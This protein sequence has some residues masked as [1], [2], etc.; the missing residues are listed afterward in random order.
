M[1]NFDNNFKKQ[2]TMKRI[3]LMLSLF[4]AVAMLSSCEEYETVYTSDLDLVYTNYSPEYNFKSA[5]TYSIP[6][7][8]VLVKDE[9]FDGTKEY[10]RY[11]VDIINAIKSNMSAYGWT[12]VPETSNPDVI[13]LPSISSTVN[14]YYYYSWGYWGSYYPGYYPGWGWSY[15]GYYPGYYPTT[16]ATTYS[17]GTLIMQ[18]TNPKEAATSDNIPVVWLGVVNGLAEGSSVEIKS[19]LQNTIKQA[20]KQSTYLKK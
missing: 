7:S 19:R 11:S 2:H 9:D 1:F 10:S 15:P 12:L 13:I 18:M 20:F 4:S 17:T 8:V 16:T 5:T 6:D 3:T 14:V